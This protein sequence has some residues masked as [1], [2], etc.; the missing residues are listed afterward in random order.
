M[1]SFQENQSFFHVTIRSYQF[2]YT[3][4]DLLKSLILGWKGWLLGKVG[5]RYQDSFVKLFV[6]L[7]REIL[8]FQGMSGNFKNFK[9]SCYFPAIIRIAF[10]NEVFLTPKLI[11]SLKRASLL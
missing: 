6:Q 3:V 7:V 1:L 10:G 2:L 4:C 8:P 11:S 9:F 5:D